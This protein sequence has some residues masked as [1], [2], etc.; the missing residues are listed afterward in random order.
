M[1]QLIGYIRLYFKEINKGLLTISAIWIAILIYL[2]YAW[3]LEGRIYYLWPEHPL[4]PYFSPAMVYALAFWPILGLHLA[5]NKK[6]MKP[7]I[8]LLLWLSPAWFA[9]KVGLDSYVPL[10]ENQDWNLYW[11]KVLYWPLRVLVLMIVLWI[12]TRSIG[13]PAEM[14]G[15]QRAGFNWKPYLMMLLLMTPLIALASTQA[16][17]LETYPKLQQVWP[18]P[19]TA[20]PG[21]FYSLLF[22][23]GYGSD[24]VS[25]E[26]FFRGFMVIGFAKWLGK[27][28]ILPMACFYCSIHFGKPL[29]ECI[30][31]FFGGLL[32]GVVSYH[33]RQI[34]GGLIVHLGI[35][36]LME[37]GGYLGDSLKG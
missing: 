21:F 18:L 22:E 15:L 12:L 20:E 1:K 8:Q 37:L 30:S 17:F 29:G 9:I 16:D 19:E 34:Y 32:L 25:I 2:N 14:L 7:G 31:S 35:A 13:R 24:F 36:W 5:L 28:S 4:S 3:D 11:N 23:L 6:P 33:S 26:V 27:D 10:S